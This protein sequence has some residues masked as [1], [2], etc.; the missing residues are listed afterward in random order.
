ML[1]L[2]RPNPQEF[3]APYFHSNVPVSRQNARRIVAPSRGKHKEHAVITR[4]QH[5]ARDLSMTREKRKT[6]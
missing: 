2:L 5:I 1:G 3:L 4:L 6:L